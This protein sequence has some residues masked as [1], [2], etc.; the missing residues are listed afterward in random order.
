[1]RLLA[2]LTLVVFCLSAAFALAGPTTADTVESY[3]KKLN[4][5]YKKGQAGEFQFSLGFPGEKT[6]KFLVRAIP[7]AKIVYLAVLDVY[8]APT[9]PAKQAAF[10]RTLAELNYNL[11]IGK[12][13]WNRETNQIRLSYTFANENGVDFETFKAVIQTL[14][15]SVSKVRQAL[16]NAG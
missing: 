2:I 16:Q 6:E 10:F 13:E 14:L 12:L 1:M 4:V 3:L 7:E 9:D 5:K 15:V 11:T 8:R